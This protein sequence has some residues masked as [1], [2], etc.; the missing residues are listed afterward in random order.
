MNKAQVRAA[1]RAMADGE[2]LWQQLQAD[3]YGPA[4]QGAL[5]MEGAREFL[6]HCR[7][8]GVEVFIVSHKTQYAGTAPT[9]LRV[10]A[11]M[12]MISQGFFRSD[13]GGLAILPE[14]VF[15]ES[16]R[17]EKLARIASL[18][19]DC[20]IDDLPEVLGDQNFPVGVQRIWFNPGGL[21]EEGM[22]GVKQ[23]DSWYAIQ[24]DMFS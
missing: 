11:Q 15:F 20:F 22:A 1:M 19:V 2:K 23:Y 18:A 12:W 16:T 24:H 6:L 21:Q 7:Q 13:E 8:V 17:L 3:V 9:G 10:A 14:R 5:L 4:M